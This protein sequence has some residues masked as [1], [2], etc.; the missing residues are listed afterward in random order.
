MAPG[1]Q[2]PEMFVKAHDKLKFYYILKSGHAVSKM[3]FV[4]R[5]LSFHDFFSDIMNLSTTMIKEAIEKK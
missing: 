1:E 2:V 3:Y 4:S 5:I